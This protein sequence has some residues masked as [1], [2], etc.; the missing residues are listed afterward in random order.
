MDIKFNSPLSL[1]FKYEKIINDNI[2][3]CKFSWIELNMNHELLDRRNMQ[4]YNCK[5]V[6]WRTLILSVFTFHGS[7]VLAVNILRDDRLFSFGA[8]SCVFSKNVFVTFC[9]VGFVFRVCA[10]IK[11]IIFKSPSFISQLSYKI[12]NN[13][14]SLLLLPMLQVLIS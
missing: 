9:F 4:R 3:V 8:F 5:I 12:V 13:L 1:P 11:Y 7:W 2:F 14:T 6:F 10:T